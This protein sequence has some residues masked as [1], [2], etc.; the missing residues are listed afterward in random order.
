MP[1]HPPIALNNFTTYFLGFQTPFHFNE[2][3]SDK[4]VFYNFYKFAL[5]TLSI[6]INF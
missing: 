6:L 1:R 2:K 4:I 5:I 3:V